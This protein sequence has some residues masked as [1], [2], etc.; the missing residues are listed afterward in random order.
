MKE[1]L[2]IFETAKLAKEK[3]FNVKVEYGVYGP[4][5]K[6]THYLTKLTNWNAESKQQKHSQA[7]SV[8]TQSLLQKWL[9]EVHDIDINVNRDSQDMYWCMVY[10][11]TKVKGP[12]FSLVYEEALEKGLQEALKFIK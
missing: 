4:K 1:Q 11:K 7:T 6:L 2:I 9:R 5:M 8:P 3:G 10:N 12:E